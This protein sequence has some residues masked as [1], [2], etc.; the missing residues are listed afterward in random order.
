MGHNLGLVIS[1]DFLSSD[2]ELR[3]SLVASVTIPAVRCYRS[4]YCTVV[5]K[6]REI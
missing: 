2:S 1:R 4:L 6:E 5:T 3:R